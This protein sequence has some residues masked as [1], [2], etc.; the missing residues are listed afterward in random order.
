VGALPWIARTI[1]VPATAH[2]SFVAWCTKTASWSAT[3]VKSTGSRGGVGVGAGVGLGVA[4]AAETEA[5]AEAVA[6]G[7]VGVG[8]GVAV[9]AATGGGV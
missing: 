2:Q 9:A 3:A 8:R 5:E 6:R 1:W 7:G 4:G